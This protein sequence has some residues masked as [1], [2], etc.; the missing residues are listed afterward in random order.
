MSVI[1][2]IILALEHPKALHSTPTLTHLHLPRTGS[3]RQFCAQHQFVTP[4][5]DRQTPPLGPTFSSPDSI[6]MS[7][8]H[9]V[10]YVDLFMEGYMYP[11]CPRLASS[12][13]GT[14]YSRL[15]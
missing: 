7:M 9:V 1:R 8:S 11:A 12:L 3:L 6:H 15:L 13:S 2:G 14:K 5:G 10:A 4:L